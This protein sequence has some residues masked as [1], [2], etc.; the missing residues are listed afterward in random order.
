MQL[1]CLLFPTTEGI[2]YG[3]ENKLNCIQ[4]FLL[5]SYI[6]KTSHTTEASPNLLSVL[7]MLWVQRSMKFTWSLPF[8][9]K[10]LDVKEYVSQASAQALLFLQHYLIIHT[11]IFAVSHF[12]TQNTHTHIV[13]LL[14]YRYSHSEC[15]PPLRHL[16]RDAWFKGWSF[17]N[18]HNFYQSLTLGCWVVC[19]GE[20]ADV[21]VV[22][23]G[24][25]HGS[26]DEGT[27][28]VADAVRA[29]EPFALP[30]GLK[31]MSR[32][33]FIAEVS[34]SFC[35]W[36]CWR[37]YSLKRQR[38][39]NPWTDY[40]NL[41]QTHKNGRM[42]YQSVCEKLLRCLILFPGT[43]TSKYTSKLNMLIFFSLPVHIYMYYRIT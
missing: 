18:L 32:R 38:A 24:M 23:V 13:M 40:A 34:S 39:S 1:N 4:S 43:I 22:E 10:K 12:H 9:K 42:D 15:I 25:P 7:D 11:D 41:R 29:P 16:A 17:V 5:L 20:A 8:R 36:F 2:F 6:A 37:L 26:R 14:K 19:C 28:G 30:W 27:G 21:L 33:S 31:L 3:L 35:C